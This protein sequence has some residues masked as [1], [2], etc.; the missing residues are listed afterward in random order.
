MNTFLTVASRIQYELDEIKKITKRIKLGW[1]KAL[2]TSDDL[3][4]DSVALN[5]HDFYNGLERL[6]EVIAENIDGVKLSGGRWHQEL[7]QQ[8]ALELKGVRPAVISQELSE[9][10]D[11]YRSF[12]HLVRNVYAH[13]FKTDR[14]KP[15]VDN[16]D[17][18]FQ[19]SDEQLNKFCN[20]LHE[21]SME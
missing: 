17:R 3:Y 8:M 13:Q 6:F 11:E 18:V 2:Q 9:K 16:I 15:L 1:T 20:Y 12:R 4:F 7:L 10:L 21:M 14:M 5:L 19:K